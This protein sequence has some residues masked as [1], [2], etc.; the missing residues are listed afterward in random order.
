MSTALATNDDA[1]SLTLQGGPRHSQ[2]SLKRRIAAWLALVVAMTHSVVI[3]LWIMPTNPIR[4]AVG[5]QRIAE[6]VQP[7]FE[8]NWSVFAPSPG[9]SDYNVVIRGFVG[10][11]GQKGDVT[12]WVDPKKE[13]ERHFTLR[14]APSRMSI[15]ARRIAGAMAVEISELSSEQVQLLRDDYFRTD[16]GQLGEQLEELVPGY[17]SSQLLLQDRRL[18]TF[19][20]LIARARWGSRVSLVQYKIVSNFVPDYANRRESRY[21]SLEPPQTEFG[22]RAASEIDEESQQSFDDYVQDGFR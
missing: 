21:G 17:E 13:A 7:F 8:Q 22:W 6:Y 16:V 15:V 20:T 12:E 1:G 11:P 2:W 10:T 9:V 5:N 14:M 3:A 18:T 19:A 4:D